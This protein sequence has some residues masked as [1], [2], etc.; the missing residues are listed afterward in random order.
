MSAVSTMIR[1]RPIA[2][3]VV[4]AARLDPADRVIDI[5][6]GPGTAVRCAARRAAA[7]AGIDP[8]PVMLGTARRMSAISRSR[9]V[10]WLAGEAEK[11]PLPAGQATVA[12]AISSVHHWSDL[13]AGLAEVSRVLAPA[14]R[15]LVVEHLAIGENSRGISADRASQLS[16]ELSAA[17]FRDVGIETVT[18]GRRTLAVISGTNPPG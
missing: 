2:H 12:W 9:N 8:D 10:T 15:L 7:A 14:G 5:G 16:E 13:A 6:C 18:A 1:R 4:D 17:G 3:A 11:L